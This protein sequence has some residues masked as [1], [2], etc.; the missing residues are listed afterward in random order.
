MSSDEEREFYNSDEC[1]VQLPPPAEL[2]D[3]KDQEDVD[4][5]AYKLSTSPL[6]TMAFDPSL[7]LPA[8]FMD[9]DD[10]PMGVAPEK[11]LPVNVSRERKRQNAS[12]LTLCCQ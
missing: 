9:N 7:G 8:N 11:I 12:I 10:E 1:P 6:P 5:E 2:K 3:V 4:E